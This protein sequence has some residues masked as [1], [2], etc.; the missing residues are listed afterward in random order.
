MAAQNVCRYFKFGHCKF[1]DTCTKLHVKEECED[2][3]TCS[4]RHPRDCKYYRDYSRCKFSDWCSYKHIIN[5]NSKDQTKEILEKL[6]NLEKT[7]KDK[8][9]II[10]ILIEKIKNLEDKILANEETFNKTTETEDLELNTTFMNPSFRFP[11]E[12]SDF[13]TKNKGG[14]QVHVRAK[15]KEISNPQSESLVLEKVVLNENE[16]ELE[17]KINF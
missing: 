16:S 17:N 4:L 6:N 15:H 2:V 11:C 1:G 10:N 14:L 5:S 13:V 7:M 12:Q 3:I 9:L 8:D